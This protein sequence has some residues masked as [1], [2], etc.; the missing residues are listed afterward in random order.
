MATPVFIITQDG[1]MGSF[2][3]PPG[4]PMLRY[5]IIEKSSKSWNA[6]TDGMYA[7]DT[8]AEWVSAGIRARAAR[9]LAEAV[10]VESPAWVANIYG[11]FRNMWTVDGLMWTNTQALVSGRPADVPDDW[12]AAA[13]FIRKYFPDHVTRVDLIRDPGKGYGSYPCVKCDQRVQYE[14]RYDALA[15]YPHGVECAAGGQHSY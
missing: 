3:C 5:S 1:G 12:H 15:I 10:R 2:L 7:L 9:M 14:A 13:V 8:D 11:Y 4:D 6:R